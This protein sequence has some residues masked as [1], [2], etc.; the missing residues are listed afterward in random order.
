MK[1]QTA[2]LSLVLSLLIITVLLIGGISFYTIKRAVV[3]LR[4]EIVSTTSQ[5]VREKIEDY[6]GRA[7]AVLNDTAN[8]L[9]R[10]HQ[11][12]ENWRD[13]GIRIAKYLDKEN[14]LSWIYYAE[15]AHGE[16]LGVRKLPGDQL[17][18]SY[19]DFSKGGMMT[20]LQCTDDGRCV[21]IDFQTFVKM[22][23][24]QTDLEPQ[25]YDPRSRPYYQ[26]ALDKQELA[27]T[28]P[29]PFFDNRLVGLSAVLPH[30]DDSGQFLGV[31]AIDFL[32]TEIQDFLR[33]LKVNQ[34]GRVFLIHAEGSILGGKHGD[35]KDEAFEKA[36]EAFKTENQQWKTDQQ[37]QKQISLKDGRFIVSMESLMKEG[38]PDFYCAIVL[39]EGV[40]LQGLRQ[41]TWLTV[42]LAFII[43]IVVVGIG[44]RLS[45]VMSSPIRHI[46]E[47]LR[48]IADYKIPER[49][50]C[51]KLSKSTQEISI[52]ADAVDKVKVSL[53]AFSKY[54]PQQLVH[55]VMRSGKEVRLGGEVREISVMFSDLE[56]FTTYSE[57]LTPD[58]VFQELSE[59][60]HVVTTSCHEYG[61]VTVT[62][63]GDGTMAF[64][65]APADLKDHATQSVR[66][67]L[68]LLQRL[69]DL[70]LKRHQ[71]VDDTELFHFKMRL[72]INT[73][74]VLCGNVGTEDRFSYSA[75]G[76]G[77]N[78]ASRLEGLN[79]IYGTQ[80]LV[81]EQTRLMS[82]DAFEWRKIDRIFVMGKTMPTVIYQPLG[83]LKKVDPQI[84]RA[85]DLY[86]RAL[87][88]YFLCEFSKARN[89]FH[90]AL[91]AHPTDPVSALMAER[92]RGYI[93]NPPSS[94]W[95]GTHL[96]QSK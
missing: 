19:S 96:A 39:P 70:N 72:G 90:K 33:G 29:Y 54:V 76:D 71:K 78:L 58:A 45:F 37:I 21:E 28:P 49:T 87:E 68:I 93:Y 63:T 91:K 56:G 62:F 47:E 61:G 73:A 7:D 81:S 84:L 95:D 17:I 82:G 48:L 16:F 51:T 26:Q 92:C 1:F 89:L 55:S 8:L 15:E 30:R 4:D 14:G 43:L 5:T 52:L 35:E 66:S 38:L 9:I 65:N 23:G 50:A 2:I 88:Q 69:D 31:F 57:S 41:T 24:L 34:Y 18:I 44:A 27:W 80:I 13:T 6:F 36:L 20:Y 10:N 25:P 32:L 11:D 22:A 12:L 85:R 46:T 60:L 94:T 42:G 77:V 67:G 53:K 3:D 74:E 75:V 40:F 59:F 79:K 86:E 83:E 64:F